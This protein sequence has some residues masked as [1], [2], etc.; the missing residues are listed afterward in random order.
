MSVIFFSC[1]YKEDPNSAEYFKH[2][3]TNAEVVISLD[4]P[5]ERIKEKPAV[6][7]AKL[8]RHLRNCDGMISVLHRTKDGVSPYV[9]YEIHLAQRSR[10]PLLVFVEDNLPDGIIPPRILQRRFSRRSIVRQVREHQYAIEI[11]KDYIEP[12]LPR[13]QPPQSRK[14]CL[15]VGSSLLPHDQRELIANKVDGSGYSP[16]DVSLIFGDKDSETAFHD[17][18]INDVIETAELAVCILEDPL[19]HSQF[20]L[21]ALRWAFV[22]MIS[23]TSNQSY[24]FDPSKSLSLQPRIV[25]LQDHSLFDDVLRHELNLFE[26]DFFDIVGHDGI[27]EYMDRLV[28][29]PRRNDRFERGT[30]AM[31]RD[32]IYG[33]N[34]T[35][36]RS[37]IGALGHQSFGFVSGQIS[38]DPSNRQVVDTQRGQVASGPQGGRA[39]ANRRDMDPSSVLSI[40]SLLQK[41]DHVSEK[42]ESQSS[43]QIQIGS[44]D[45]SQVG[46]I[47][48]HAKGKVSG[49]LNINAD[50]ATQID[51]QALKAALMDLYSAL[52][53]SNLPQD[54]LITAQGAVSTAINQDIKD[55]KVEPEGLA[56]HVELV[57]KTLQE[58]NV[59]VQEGTSLWESVQKL[60]PLVGP[61]VGGARVVLQLFGIPV[62]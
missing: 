8:E 1:A 40:S 25:N 11:L 13:Y 18:V 55:D 14:S 19:R 44:I 58:A 17:E 21:G 2:L 42:N 16:V 47:G 36:D 4:P 20:L 54:K 56:S 30:R 10:K 33:P 52:G 45:R 28:R 38:T 23:L 48:P 6:N 41:E 9:L 7:S 35:V 62:P 60:A 39:R 34:I 50:A 31:F 59:A 61:I 49:P 12:D 5:S 43:D 24:K 37:Q 22:P 32:L 27:K 29:A 57:G 26:E 3:I 53:Q 51:A 15:L 46:A